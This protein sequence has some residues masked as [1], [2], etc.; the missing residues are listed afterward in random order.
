MDPNSSEF[1]NAVLE[2]RTRARK[3]NAGLDGQLES[4]L[5]ADYWR[6]LNPN[7]T[8][9]GTRRVE[10]VESPNIGSS[11]VTQAIQTLSTSGYFQMPVL[12]VGPAV[13]RMRMCFEHTRKSGWPAAFVFVYDE[14]WRAFRGP[15]LVQFLTEA[16]GKGYGQLPYVWGHYVPT[17]SK[18]WRPHVDGPSIL[19]KLT[20]WLALS[21]ATLENGCMYVVGRTA[22]TEKISDS[23]LDDSK[24]FQRDDVMKLLQYAKALPATAGS[25][26]GWG[27][28]VVHWGSVSSALAPHRLSVSVE[29]A[30][31]HPNPRR[32]ELPFLE[33]DPA[34]PLPAFETRLYLIAKAIRSYD[35]FESGLLR[36]QALAEQVIRRVGVDGVSPPA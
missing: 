15:A 10:P 1:M 25:Y 31:P 22:E 3:E 17:N 29:F 13:E 8:V 24:S 32:E 2:L 21:D 16:L 6:E 14:L 9:C 20:V 28:N 12:A 5:D 27:P 4:A 11:V 7:M 33:G 23:F 18:G 34:A 36:Y 35:R 19:N 30:S 26:I